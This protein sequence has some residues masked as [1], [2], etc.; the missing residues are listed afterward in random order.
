M[1]LV[2]NAEQ[3]QEI[4]RC[5]RQLAAVQARAQQARAQQTKRKSLVLTARAL[6]MLARD[7]IWKMYLKA[8][9]V[10]TQPRDRV[11]GLLSIT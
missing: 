10:G 4:R 5:R 2:F 9:P 3:R 8:V 6:D 11:E 1:T 7:T